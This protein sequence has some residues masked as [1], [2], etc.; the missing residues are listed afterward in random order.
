MVRPKLLGVAFNGMSSVWYDSRMRSF[1]TPRS[2]A[3]RDTTSENGLTCVY[4]Y[5]IHCV[6]TMVHTYVVHIH[7]Y[8]H[9][10]T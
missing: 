3:K 6:Y 4:M 8:M 2:S 1:M 5:V 7:I 9:I 10:H